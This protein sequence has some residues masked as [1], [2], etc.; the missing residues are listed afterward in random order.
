MSKVKCFYCHK[1]GHFASQ[2]PI[3]KKNKSKSKLVAS[4]KIEDF[5]SR[6][7]EDFGLIAC[8]LSFESTG[9]GVLQ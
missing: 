5:S 3:K 2:C 6:F 9:E 8:M 4:T 1:L 7:E